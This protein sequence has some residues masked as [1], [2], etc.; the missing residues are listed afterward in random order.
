MVSSRIY[1][2]VLQLQAGHKTQSSLPNGITPS[3]MLK[4]QMIIPI[5]KG[6]ANKEAISGG[7]L[8]KAYRPP[9][10]RSQ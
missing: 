1:I 6:I 3:N 5:T 10:N 4:S 8:C 2:R 7:A 9:H